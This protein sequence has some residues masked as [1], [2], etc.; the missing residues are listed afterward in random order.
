MRSPA[1]PGRAWLACVLCGLVLS[2]AACAPRSQLPVALSDQEFWT[3]I[4]ALSEPAGTFSVSD[5]FV[6]NEPHLAENVRRLRPT[7]V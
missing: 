2:G 6:S 1:R 5:N 3:L 4:E 7:A